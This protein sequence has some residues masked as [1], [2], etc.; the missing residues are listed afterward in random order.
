MTTFSPTHFETVLRDPS[1]K[2]FFAY[3]DPLGKGFLATCTIGPPDRSNAPGIALPSVSFSVAPHGRPDWT[4]FNG[5]RWRFREIEWGELQLSNVSPSPTI[6]PEWQSDREAWNLL[7]KKI[8]D[9]IAA[10]MIQKAV[11]CRWRSTDLA[12]NSFGEFLTKLA[13]VFAETNIPGTHRFLFKSGDS[14]F[15]GFTPELLYRR[16]AGKVVVP[17]IAGTKKIES[18]PENAARDLVD[19]PKDQAEHDIVVEGIIKDLK[20]LGLQPRISRAK[21]PLQAGSLMHL[22]SEIE[23]DL[24]EEKLISAEELVSALHPT[25]AIGGFPKEAAGILLK[26]HEGWDR[27]VFSHPI[28]IRTENEEFGLIAI[29]SSLVRL[30]RVWQFAG[31]GFVA[32]SE[33]E[34]EWLETE[35]K[36]E[37]LS[38]FFFE[39]NR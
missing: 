11:P 32:A 13:A 7:C 4:D 21:S 33:S 12:P 9:A 1:G 24:P 18:T 2:T 3:F 27:G 16:E 26:D 38:R 31:A 35:H 19:S 23:A 39:V 30:G 37:S 8:K 14:V 6:R 15:F 29:R 22:H 36:M 25:A 10:G 17:A 28:C 34:S 20:F 5:K